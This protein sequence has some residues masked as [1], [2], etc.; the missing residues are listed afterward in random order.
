VERKRKK[1]AA[2]DTSALP[3]DNVDTGKI[4]LLKDDIKVDGNVLCKSLLQDSAKLKLIIFEKMFL[5]KQNAPYI[6]H[7]SLPSSILVGFPTYPSKFESLYT[8]K[9]QSI[10]NWYKNDA[11][12]N[13]SNVWTHVGSGFLYEPNVSDIGC[14]LKISC[15]P[16]NESD[17]GCNME[18]E[19]KNVV[20]AGPGP[21]PF[22]IRHQFTKHKLLGR[23]YTY[24]YVYGTHKM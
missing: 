24:I 5:V 9:K 14:N 15:E 16:R 1:D 12:N 20:E 4:M 23:R 7:M 10:F 11:I 21:C 3:N 8:D 17:S 6:I 19:S 13:K 18:V 22:D 2:L